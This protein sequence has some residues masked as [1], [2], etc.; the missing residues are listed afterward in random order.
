MAVQSELNQSEDGGLEALESETE[1][2]PL[3]GHAEALLHMVRLFLHSRHSP[4]GAYDELIGFVKKYAGRYVVKYPQLS[5][6]VQ[7]TEGLVGT[8]LRVLADNGRCGLEYDR[9]KLKAFSY[10]AYYSEVIRRAF[11]ALMEHPEDPFPS[12]KSL[13]VELP[14]GIVTAVN[15]KTEFVDILRSSQGKPPSI[16]KLVFPELIDAV[17]VTSDLVHRRLL[18]LA[19]LKMRAYL[20]TRNNASYVVNR[21]HSVFRSGDRALKEMINSIITRPG[22]AM[23]TLF[24]T[25]DFY[26]RFWAHFANLVIQ[27]FRERKD[28]SAEEQSYC[29][30]AYLLGYYNVYFKGVVQKESER[31]AAIK[32]FETQFRKAPYVY[33]LRDLYSAKDSRGM[34]L[35]RNTNRDV[36]VKFIDERSSAKGQELPQLVRLKADTR[37]EYYV[38][39]E[40][41]VPVFLRLVREQSESLRVRYLD[42][43]EQLLRQG[44]RTAAMSE[45]REFERDVESLLKASSPVMNALLSY[46]LLMLAR[47][48]AAASHAEMARQLSAYLDEKNLRLRPL[49]QI[50]GLERKALYE[51]ARLRLPMWQRYS[52]LRNLRFAMQGLLR[53]F[54][55]RDHGRQA[56]EAAPGSSGG[57]L[58]APAGRQGAPSLGHMLADTPGSGRPVGG[59]GG[60]AGGARLE[61]RTAYRKALHELKIQFVGKGATIPQTMAALAEKWNPLYDPKARANLVE[62]VNAMIRDYVR[63]LRRGFRIK[64]PDASRLR[65]LAQKLAQNEAFNRIKHRDYF[66]RYIEIYMIRLL[67]ER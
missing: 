37:S 13:G 48:L 22:K 17:L 47:E 50:L 40:M 67:G 38:H 44:R 18:E 61:Q 8:Y 23:A 63:G 7:R 27:E 42:D 4:R 51:A 6:F 28:S 39:R 36:F 21:L 60:S 54:G 35:V 16:L 53:L 5:D 9:E 45:D 12:E 2:K 66:Q 52:L 20:G 25:S 32:S 26:F 15:I 49:A 46:N 59:A 14:Q 62:D 29:Q 65:A 30:S 11:R 3:E 55:R 34:P 43:W 64:P 31:A 56:P 19:V 1:Q 10:P 24:E 57:G 41:V 33:S 58:S